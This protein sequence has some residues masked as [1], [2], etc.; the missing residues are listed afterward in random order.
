MNDD[1]EKKNPNPYRLKMVTFS[2][3]DKNYY[4]MSSNGITFVRSDGY[5]GKSIFR[6]N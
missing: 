4:T 3:I 5:T 2:E 1:I 6:Y